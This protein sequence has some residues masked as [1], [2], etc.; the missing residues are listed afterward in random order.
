[1]LSSIFEVCYHSSMDDPHITDDTIS[2]DEVLDDEVSSDSGA[3][4]ECPTCG[5]ITR[6]EVLFLCNTCEK[7]ELIHKDGMYVCPSCFTP[8]QNFECANCGSREVKLLSLN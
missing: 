1:M 8:G 5:P 3:K 2:E 4:F 7:D 6:D